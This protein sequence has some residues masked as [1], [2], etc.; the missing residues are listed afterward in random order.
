VD[1]LF[2]IGDLNGRILAQS[3]LGTDWIC[4]LPLS[5]SKEVIRTPRRAFRGNL[6]SQLVPR[7]HFQEFAV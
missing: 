2:V 5:L 3:S 7:I 6:I 4:E 1:D